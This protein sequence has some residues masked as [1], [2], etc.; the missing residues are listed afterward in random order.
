MIIAFSISFIAFSILFI[1]ASII[2]NNS[3]VDIFWGL[4]FVLISWILFFINKKYTPV[5]IIGNIIV[6]IWGLR[7]FYH[8]LKRNIF[9][10]EDFRYRNWREQW[11]THFYLRSYFQIFFLQAIFQFLIGSPIFYLNTV[12][13]QF[14]YFSIIGIVVFLIGFIFEATSDYQL[15]RHI[16]SGNKGLYTKGFFRVSRHPNYFG[17]SLIWIGIFI[18]FVINTNNYFFIVSPVIITCVLR[19]IST[20]MLEKDLAKMPEYRE[21]QKRTSM[22][23]P[24]IGKK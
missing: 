21:Y 1:I 24:F 9:K 15:K 16:K 11:K 14:N 22:F 19:F 3:I 2:K 23:I 12:D 18:F 4:G 6:S 5:A 13:T 20:P 8:I 17:E 7:L 10:G